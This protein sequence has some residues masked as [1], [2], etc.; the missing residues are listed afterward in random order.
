VISP[1]ITVDG[2]LEEWTASPSLVLDDTQRVFGAKAAAADLRV[3]LMLA[4]GSTQLAFALQ[5]EDDCPALRE[6]LPAGKC[7][8]ALAAERIALGFDGADDG[9]SSYGTGDLW[10]EIEA[11]GVAVH[12]GSASPAQLSVMVAPRA[13]LKGWTVEGTLSLSALG[14]TQLTGNDR[15]G[16]DLV[17]VDHD[18]NEPQPTVLRWS[19]ALGAW[20]EPTSPENMCTLGFGE[21][22]S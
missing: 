20:S 17:V 12:R 8:T 3:E 14:R 16:F 1:S 19:G 13:D 21:P 5:V 18:P 2:N 7:G 22:K 11:T 10:L 4:W 15:V 9:G 6:G